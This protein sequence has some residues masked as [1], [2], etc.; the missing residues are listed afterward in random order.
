[1]GLAGLRPKPMQKAHQGAIA[2]ATC[3]LSSRAL[4]KAALLQ[5]GQGGAADRGH[6]E[7]ERVQPLGVEE[8]AA[9]EEE[10]G[11]L[12]LRV[13]PLVVQLAVF[14]PVGEQRDRVGAPGGRVGVLLGA[15]T[16]PGGRRGAPVSA[17]DANPKR[18]MPLPARVLNI[19]RIMR[20][21][22]R[23]FW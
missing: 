1:L 15:Y 3:A 5:A 7:A 11:L 20:S 8:V 10:R 2:G 13:D 17:L 9:G 18:A 21:T 6:V 19:A 14:A 12:H 16:R 23:R 4:G 22:K